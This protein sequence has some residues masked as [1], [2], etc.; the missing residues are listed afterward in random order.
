MPMR[1]NPACTNPHCVKQQTAYRVRRSSHKGCGVVEGGGGGSHPR[2]SRPRWPRDHRH[3]RRRLWPVR[4]WCTRTIAGVRARMGRAKVVLTDAHGAWWGGTGIEVQRDDS[5]DAAPG[6]AGSVGAGDAH[7]PPGLVYA[8]DATPAA[9]VVRAVADAVV[10][11]DG[12]THLGFPGR[13]RGAHT[14]LGST[15]APAAVPVAA[16]AVQPHAHAHPSCS[17]WSR[18]PRR[19]QEWGLSRRCHGRGSSGRL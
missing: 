10:W 7:L 4:R 19:V 1:P 16:R 3:R 15:A 11:E 6:P 18:P 5:D 12:L 17:P 9:D 8:F 2:L 13:G 14:G